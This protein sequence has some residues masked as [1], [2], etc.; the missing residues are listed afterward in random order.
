MKTE[1]K[2]AEKKVAAQRTK[3]ADAL[4]MVKK[5]IDEVE[6]IFKKISYCE[7][8]MSLVISPLLMLDHISLDD[9]GDDVLGFIHKDGEKQN[10][11]SVHMAVGATLRALAW[12]LKECDNIF[13]GLDS[14]LRGR[15][16]EYRRFL[17]DP[18]LFDQ[19]KEVSGVTT[20]T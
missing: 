14:E 17:E 20:S 18:T 10:Q 2:V 5:L 4:A 13:D 3:P 7:Y 19:E 1:K 11:S 12:K 9:D 6:G 8:E 16:K 15:L